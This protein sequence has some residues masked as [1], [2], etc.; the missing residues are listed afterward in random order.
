M[1]AHDRE[2]LDAGQNGEGHRSEGHSREGQ[3]DEGHSGEG[4]HF[5]VHHHVKHPSLEHPFVKHPFVMHPSA[6]GDLMSE[7]PP[8]LAAKALDELEI[9]DDL[10]ECVQQAAKRSGM[11]YASFVQQ[12][13]STAFASLP[14]WQQTDV[15]RLLWLAD[16][17]GLDPLAKELIAVESEEIFPKA[18]AFM[19]TL[20]G[21]V[22]LLHRHPRFKGM[23]F[24][25]GP[26]DEQGYPLWMSCTLYWEGFTCPWVVK[27]WA[28]EH[29]SL[30]ELWLRYPRRMLRH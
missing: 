6:L 9:P 3:D 21:W 15:E 18:I 27:E 17:L 19:I 13:V 10:P 4:H 5:D 1:T 8:G 26:L 29:R 14:F 24:E 2:H 12:L 16:R 28:Q 20:D 30:H 23:A 11:R 25:E 22:K 7:R